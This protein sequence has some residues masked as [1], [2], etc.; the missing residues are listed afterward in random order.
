MQEPFPCTMLTLVKAQDQY[1][2]ML[3]PVMEVKVTSLS[4]ALPLHLHVCIAVMPVCGAQVRKLHAWNM[5]QQY[6]KKHYSNY[7]FYVLVKTR[8][9][10][11]I[12]KERESVEL[13]IYPC[14]NML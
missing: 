5:Y 3:L 9:Y 4:V 6:Q 13:S 7:T 1:I 14:A 2:S 11:I 10:N 12:I 8:E